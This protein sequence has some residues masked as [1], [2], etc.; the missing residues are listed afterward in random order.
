VLASGTSALPRAGGWAAGA[1]VACYCLGPGSAACRRPLGQ[2]YGRITRS[3][4]GAT[5]G[6]IALAL[7]AVVTVAAATSLAP[8]YWPDAHL[9]QQLQSA[10]LNHPLLSHLPGNLTQVSKRVISWVGHRL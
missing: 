9:G 3:G 4:L 1:I 5:A 2:F 10:P 7:L 8:G 6:F